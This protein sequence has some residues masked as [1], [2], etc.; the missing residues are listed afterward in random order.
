MLATHLGAP[1]LEQSLHLRYPPAYH[2]QRGDAPKS[3][4][5]VASDERTIS[6]G[7]DPA[8]SEG[9]EGLPATER[10]CRRS[11]GSY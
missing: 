5:P 9:N 8:S 11:G 6:F 2:A 1:K 10:K 4:C 3:P 7:F